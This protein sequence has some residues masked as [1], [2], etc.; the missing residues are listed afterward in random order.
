MPRPDFEKK[1]KTA[2]PWLAGLAALVMTLIGIS[3]IL[4]WSADTGPDVTVPTVEDT[5]PPADIPAPPDLDPPVTGA[6]PAPGVEEGGA[7]PGE[8][9]I[10]QAISLE[11]I[12]ATAGGPSRPSPEA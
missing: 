4:S 9:E 12:G 8:E 5:H 7:P 1:R 3:A 11:G 10:G 2:W 6:D